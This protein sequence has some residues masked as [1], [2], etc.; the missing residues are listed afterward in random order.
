MSQD[1]TTTQQDKQT[2]PSLL[3]GCAKVVVVLV[4]ILALVYGGIHAS[5]GDAAWNPIGRAFVEQSGGSW[6]MFIE[7][8][9]SLPK[10]P[11]RESVPFILEAIFEAPMVWWIGTIMGVLMGIG[12]VLALEKQNNPKE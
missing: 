11:V 8:L 6:G 9:K 7:I 2:N 3:A 1:E 10:M 4:G 5:I 12:V